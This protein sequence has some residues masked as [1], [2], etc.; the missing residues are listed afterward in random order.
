MNTWQYQY[1]DNNWQTPLTPN[2]D[3]QWVLVFGDRNLAARADIRQQIQSAFPNAQ[4]MGCS[5]SGAI[6]G[7]QLFDASLVVSVVQF[8]STQIVTATIDQNIAA[9]DSDFEAGKRL[10]EKLPK[11]GLRYAM[12][13]STGHAI[14]GAELVR[15]L[16]EELPKSV[17]LTGGLAGDDDRFQETEVWCNGQQS[18]RLTVLCGLYGDKLNI[19]HGALGGW[20]PFGPTRLITKAESNVL[21]ELDGEN[22]LAL[23]KKYLGDYAQDL[24]ASALLFPL[25]VSPK[26]TPD[27]AIVRTILNI[28]ED[29]QSMIFAGTMPEGYQ[30][31]LMR[32]NFDR[33]IDGAM[34]AAEKAMPSPTDS[35]PD[36]ALVISCVGRRLL[37]KQRAEEEL[38]QV[39]EVVGSNCLTTGFYSYGEISPVSNSLDC[40]LHN[41]TMTITTFS[42]TDA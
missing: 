4:Y 30:A 14:D 35:Q 28:D 31:R 38:E 34:G 11:E 19:G 12:A 7:E 2:P 15:G 6:A 1:K 42:E 21:Y 20:I 41:Q 16:R 29:N 32:A 3:A 5:T 23:Y 40:R 13:L 8:S 18:T 10:V 22:A 9:C 39:Q 27:D 17:V 24:P 25:E 33:L 26:D 37:L 36:F